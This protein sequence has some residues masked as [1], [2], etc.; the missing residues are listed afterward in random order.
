MTPST[1]GRPF[2][3]LIVDWL[4]LLFCLFSCFIDDIAELN[5]YLANATTTLMAQPY[6]NTDGPDMWSSTPNPDIL[7]TP[8]PHTT[9]EF[10]GKCMILLLGNICNNCCFVMKEPISGV[11]ILFFS[12]IVAQF[13][14]YACFFVYKFEKY[15]LFS[16]EIRRYFE[17]LWYKE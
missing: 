11:S 1:H 4:F 7:N 12:T 15:W 8:T 14:A 13:S 17:E 16:I 5:D 2:T 3:S 9:L 6:D 10:V